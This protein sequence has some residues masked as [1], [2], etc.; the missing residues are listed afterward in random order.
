M[1]PCTHIVVL[2][3]IV[4]FAAAAVPPIRE[5]ASVEENSLNTYQN[6]NNVNYRLPNTSHP[7][8]YE[9]A[10]ESRVDLG[11]FE[12]KGNVKIVI[13][14]DQMTQEIV[15]HARQL[16]ILNVTLGRFR[17]RTLVNL[18]IDPFEYDN[19]PEFLKIRTNLSTLNQGDRLLLNIDYVG[20]LRNDRGGFYRSS[21]VN[22]NGVLK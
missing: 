8:N 20:A 16:N 1:N 14:V 15:L 22:S 18:K 10:I 6:N 19:V 11:E 17:G 5:L 4:A 7:V 13:V 2:A 9:L 21:Y 12:F 3:H